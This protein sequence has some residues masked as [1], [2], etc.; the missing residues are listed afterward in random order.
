MSISSRT[1]LFLR[2][3][4]TRS[5]LQVEW[6][7]RQFEPKASTSTGIGDQAD[8]KS[9]GGEIAF[10]VHGSSESSAT[11]NLLARDFGDS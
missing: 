6:S 11:R 5:T 10:V 1:I 3:Q 7:D 4:F 9:Q 2:C 8:G